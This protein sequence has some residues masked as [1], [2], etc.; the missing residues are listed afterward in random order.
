M[1]L[2]TKKK[3]RRRSTIRT[4]RGGGAD[5]P[6]V[7]K[8]VRVPSFSQDLLSKTAGLTRKTV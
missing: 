5:G 4:V 3:P 2:D 6:R 8:S 7:P 1:L